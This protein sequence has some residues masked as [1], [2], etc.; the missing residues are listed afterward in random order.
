MRD[1]RSAS[2]RTE[3]PF[4]RDSKEKRAAWRG[5]RPSLAAVVPKPLGTIAIRSSGLV[6][7]DGVSRLLIK[8]DS[9]G[10]VNDLNSPHRSKHPI[11]PIHP[12]PRHRQ[13]RMDSATFPSTTSRETLAAPLARA[14]CSAFDLNGSVEGGA[15]PVRA[16]NGFSGAAVYR[17][18]DQQG[19]VWAWRSTS[20][21]EVDEARIGQVARWAMGWSKAG[22]PVAVFRPAVACGP[23]RQQRSPRYLFSPP[24]QPDQ[25]WMVEPWLPGTSDYSTDPSPDR[26][27]E[28]M[29]SLARLHLATNGASSL[30]GSE[31]SSPAGLV[32]RCAN[33]D[34]SSWA[35]AAFADQFTRIPE[36]LRSTATSFREIATRVGPEIMRAAESACHLTAPSVVCIRD[37]WHDHLLFTGQRLTGLIDLHSADF[38]CVAAD[39]TRLLGS[40]HPFSPGRWAEALTTYEEVRPIVREERMLLRPYERT[41]VLLSGIYWL[42]RWGERSQASWAIAAPQQVSREQARLSELL[43]RMIGPS[44]VEGLCL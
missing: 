7:T 31:R 25:L 24:D 33:P 5:R 37:L 10:S 30:L 38:D 17:W 3:Q 13:S 6:R 39:L 21:Q 12:T 1:D 28:V 18:T 36:P 15:A 40:L 43:Q 4:P 9:T 2:L 34:Y 42:R 19:R 14:I 29:R 8:P 23:D 22:L 27:A 41:S 26:L 20:A 16:G 35:S 11:A 44:P 32:R